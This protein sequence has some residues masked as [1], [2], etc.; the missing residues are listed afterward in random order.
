MKKKRPLFFS[1]GN[2]SNS[3]CNP[4]IIAIFVGAITPFTTIVGAHLEWFLIF[5]ASAKPDPTEAG[6]EMFP[7]LYNFVRETVDDVVADLIVIPNMV[8]VP[9]EPRAIEGCCFVPVCFPKTGVPSLKNNEISELVFEYRT[10]HPPRNLLF[11]LLMFGGHGNEVF[12]F[13]VYFLSVWLE[14]VSER[15]SIH[16]WIAEFVTLLKVYTNR[17]EKTGV[18][19]QKLLYCY[20][21]A[22]IVTLL[23]LKDIHVLEGPRNLLLC[24]PFSECDDYMPHDGVS[25]CS[26]SRLI[27]SRFWTY[28]MVTSTS[29]RWRQGEKPS[30]LLACNNYV[31]CDLFLG[32]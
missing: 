14:S 10:P 19:G 16:L 25:E 30:I 23:G 5:L 12:A 22:L 2:F 4:K 20:P 6:G 29:K 26:K 7:N 32:L 15:I 3:T 27:Y 31:L 13:E 18:S 9:I 17:I 1:Y 21:V 11:F 28:K 24:F 8:A